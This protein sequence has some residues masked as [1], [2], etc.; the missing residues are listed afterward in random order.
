MRRFVYWY[1]PLAAALV[2][3]S[4][5]GFG[6]WSFLTGNTGE[7]V[8]IAPATSTA[9][10]PAAQTS[11]VPVI[12]G[13]SLARGAGDET[14]LGIAGRL[15]EELRKRKRPAKT[16]VNLGINGARTADLVRQLES[17]NVK[18]MLGQANV[19]VISIGGNDLWGGSDWRT[20]APENPDVVMAG[21]LD[22]IGNVVKTVR[23]ANP[24]ARV[25]FIGLYNP[26]AATPMG[27]RLNGLVNR[28]NGKLLERFGS[29]PNFTVVQT[30]DLFSH[31]DRL[32]LDR[33]HP[34]AEG[35]AL[36]ARRIAD[37]L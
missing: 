5:F 37:G 21:V 2:A 33:F 18:S 8:N 17:P 35:Y 11:V 19:I 24:K 34:G 15:D 27:P 14:G 12:V 23:D 6:L 26:F 28:W 25:F 3:V 4:V 32:A 7:A 16:T 13:D 1:L 29:D 20:A 9:A 31:H 36:I 10:A 22:R 30:A